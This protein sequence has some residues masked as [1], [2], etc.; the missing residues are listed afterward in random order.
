MIGRKEAPPLSRSVRMFEIIQLLR[1]A[2]APL[3]AHAIAALLEVT[4]RTVYRDIAALQAMRVPIEGAAGLGYVM[5][6]GF[7][8][9]PL[10]FTSEE[11][12]AI[13]VGLALLGRTGDADLEAAAAGAARKIGAVLPENRGREL[14]DQPLYA[15][16]WH[17][18]PGARVAPRLLRRAVREEEKLQLSYA[19]AEGRL[20][21]RTVLPLAVVY[22]IESVVLA[23]WCELRADFRHFR[24]DRMAACQ[25]TGERFAGQG[26]QLRARWREQHGLT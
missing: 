14:K 12:E 8:L 24:L 15:S 11:L 25:P 9:P 3:T 22:H 7:D 4:K 19:D 5:R 10:T 6:P 2:D 18:I 16:R 17:A 26:P 13:V 23:A 1:S 21:Q 20:T